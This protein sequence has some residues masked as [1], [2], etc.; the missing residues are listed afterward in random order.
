V[1]HKKKKSEQPGANLD[2]GVDIGSGADH[3]A[4]AAVDN[5]VIENSSDGAEGPAARIKAL[6]QEKQEI[7]DRLLRTMAEFDNYRKRVTREK[8]GLLK[9]R[10]ERIA[11]EVLPV[12]DSFERALEQSREATDVGPVVA[13]LEMILK[14][15]MAALEKFEVAPFNSIGEQ[16]N[17]E[18]HEA[19]AQQ[20][21]PD[22]EDNTVIDQFQKGYMIGEKLLRPARVLV[23]R[24]PAAA[25]GP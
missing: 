17:P 22:K 18:V 24:A 19:M 21:H 5:A 23:S 2:D 13:G 7:S 15:L 3:A 1:S 6:E 20:E 10:T 4:G 11:A 25:G 8:E 12:V 16:F 9:Y 14:Q